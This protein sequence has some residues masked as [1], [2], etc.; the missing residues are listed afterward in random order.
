LTDCKYK[1]IDQIIRKN[2]ILILVETHWRINKFKINCKYILEKRRNLNEKKGGGIMILSDKFKISQINL[3]SNS[4]DALAFELTFNSLK[5]KILALYFDVIDY[6]KNCLLEIELMK[7]YSRFCTENLMLI[8]DFNAHLE[9]LDNRTNKNTI[10]LE[11]ILDNTDLLL[12]NTLQNCTGRYTWERKH[13]KTVIDFALASES[14]VQKIRSVQIDDKKEFDISDHNFMFISFKLDEILVKDSKLKTKII[15][16]DVEKNL[17][18][19][20]NVSA[21]LELNNQISF[22]SFETLM[23]NEM[24]D[25]LKVDIKGKKTWISRT[26]INMIKKRKAINRQK[27]KEKNPIF[28]EYLNNKYIELKNNIKSLVRKEK[29][30]EEEKLSND[31]RNDNFAKWRFINNLKACPNQNKF[32]DKVIDS[33]NR[34]IS[35]EEMRRSF[36]SFW[37]E[38]FYDKSF[39]L[40]NFNAAQYNLPS[41]QINNNSL[42]YETVPLIDHSYCSNEKYIPINWTIDLTELVREI[43]CLKNKKAA[44]CNGIKNECFKILGQNQNIVKYLEEQFNIIIK[45]GKTPAS[46][47]QSKVFLI[48]KG[49]ENLTSLQNFRP[50]AISSISY[51]LFGG[52]IRNKLFEFCMKNKLLREE[53][54]GFFPNRRGE[55]NLLLMKLEVEKSYNKNRSLWVGSIDIKKAFDSVNRNE[56]IQVLVKYK[57]PYEIIKVIYSILKQEECHMY[58]NNSNIGT[59]IKNKGIKQGCRLSPLLFNLCMNEIIIG[60]NNV[61]DIS[62]GEFNMLCYADDVLIVANSLSQLGA[63]VK[64]FSRIANRF[65]LEINENKSHII[66]FNCKEDKKEYM[67]MKIV[68]EIKY[69][70]VTIRNKR[71]LFSKHMDL[72]LKRLPFF[73]HLIYECTSARLNKILIGKT[74]WQQIVIPTIMYG[75][76]CIDY[77]KH[78]VNTLEKCQLR[79][80]KRL[81]SLPRYTPNSFIL[82]ECRL[83]TI[84]KKINESKLL[85]YRHCQVNSYIITEH[86]DRN[87]FKSKY[88]NDINL[89]SQKYNISEEMFFHSKHAMKKYL[90]DYS[91][92]ELHRNITENSLLSIYKTIQPNKCRFN[93]VSCYEHKILA[94]FQSGAII[95]KNLKCETCVKDI[96]LHHILEC[97]NV[98]NL[99]D[100][101]PENYRNLS[102]LYGYKRSD[103][104]PDEI[105][106]KFCRFII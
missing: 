54:A 25:N 42:A 44:D 102:F 18:F 16:N 37:E 63:K 93:W 53:Q 85:L 38:I 8:G 103:Y 88:L 75:S 84:E 3:D 79:I 17:K 76:S 95:R 58:L 26:L 105:L 78:Q 91:K 4:N 68:D 23:V 89:I 10:I 49:R 36:L 2:V 86:L 1:E 59:V 94:L 7:F 101:M 39:T 92:E 15:F 41:I 74:I 21:Q 14:V 27:R 13:S 66:C 33:K 35:G 31:L 80:F 72:K 6:E 55:E 30:Q 45:D 77:T 47:R 56:L 71:N 60:I 65:N 81:M 12:L 34:V 82:N 22:T 20:Q 11:R 64:E 5:I 104:N 67:G 73:E 32:F 28:Y 9:F 57:V 90:L 40:N 70:G 50:I 52:L 99:I 24:E 48:Q 51:K 69:L 61:W 96:T 100:S 19:V 83:F 62:A 46:W 97:K 43:Q 87:S 98:S 29:M 106:V